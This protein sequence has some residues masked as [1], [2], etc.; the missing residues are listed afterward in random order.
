[1]QTGECVRLFTGHHSA[2]YSVA[3]SPDG[4]TMASGSSDGTVL[5]WDLGSSRK[6]GTLSGHTAAVWDLTYRCVRTAYGRIERW[7]MGDEGCGWEMSSWFRVGDELTVSPLRDARRFPSPGLYSHVQLRRERLGVVLQAKGVFL[8]VR[9]QLLRYWAER[10][11]TPAR[12][13]RVFPSRALAL[14]ALPQPCHEP[15]RR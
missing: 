9:S 11:P 1:M 6:L 4:R 13:S 15:L 2:I 12:G 8:M 7:V 14:L 5:L 10:D 3:M